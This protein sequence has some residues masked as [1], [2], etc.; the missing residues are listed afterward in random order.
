MFD[1]FKRKD[2]TVNINHLSSNH[3]FAGIVALDDLSNNHFFA[4]VVALEVEAQ[5]RHKGTVA[6]RHLPGIADRQFRASEILDSMLEA[7]EAK[8]DK[9]K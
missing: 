7:Y 8:A 5:E 4:G 6:S 9:A 3:F 1:L 2:K